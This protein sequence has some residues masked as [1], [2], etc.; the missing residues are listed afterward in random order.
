MKVYEWYK[1][2]IIL[3]IQ[4]KHFSDPKDSGK[5]EVTES[6]QVTF[7]KAFC[8]RNIFICYFNFPGVCSLSSD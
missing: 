8:E 1:Q 2:D 7:W 5:L 4:M 6:V 3:A